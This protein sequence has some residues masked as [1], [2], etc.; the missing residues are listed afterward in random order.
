MDDIAERIFQWSERHDK[1]I[2]IACAAVFI[3]MLILEGII[4]NG[5]L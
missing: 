4:E 2:K 5:N 3:A 1:G